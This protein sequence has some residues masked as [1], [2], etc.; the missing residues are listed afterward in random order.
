MKQFSSTIG[1]LGE[2]IKGLNQALGSIKNEMTQN[3][4]ASKEMHEKVIGFNQQLGEYNQHMQQINDKYKDFL[5]AS[6]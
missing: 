2:Q 4:Q 5:A 3:A 6:K 1:E